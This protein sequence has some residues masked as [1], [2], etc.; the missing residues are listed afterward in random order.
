[1]GLRIH[2][3][4]AFGG[5]DCGFLITDYRLQITDC[6]LQIHYVAAFGGGGLLISDC[7]FTAWLPSAVAD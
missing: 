7:G 1:M 5:A 6:G 4:A 3:V 2:C